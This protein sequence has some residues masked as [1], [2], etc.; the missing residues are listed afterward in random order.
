MKAPGCPI[1]APN[2]ATPI[3]LPVCRVAFNTPA[4]T[5]DRDFSTLPSRVEV[6]GGTSRPSPLLTPINCRP[7][8]Q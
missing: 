3:T 4:T 8:A 1:S 6:N 2:K 7:T 5:P